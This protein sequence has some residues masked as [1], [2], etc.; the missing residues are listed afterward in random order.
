MV[1]TVFI[2]LS[3]LCSQVLA[4]RRAVALPLFFFS[5]ANL[6]AQ[7]SL[8]LHA[9]C[10]MTFS[11]TKKKYL[12]FLLALLLSTLALHAKGE[13]ADSMFSGPLAPLP[14][15]LTIL[16]EGNPADPLTGL[17]SVEGAFD[18]GKYDVTV[19]QWSIFLNAVHVTEGN[20]NDPRGLYPQEMLSQ[21]NGISPLEALSSLEKKEIV[22][23][24]GVEVIE[25]KNTFFFPH[26]YFLSVALKILS[27]DYFCA[28]L[29]IT[30][31]SR[32][33]AKRYC[34]WLHHGAPSFQ[35]LNEWTLLFTETGAYDFT[36]GKNGEL[37]PGARYFIP[38]LQQWYKAAYYHAL[39]QPTAGYF[40][41][42]TASNL[43]PKRLPSFENYFEDPSQPLQQHPNVKKTGA[44][45]A[46]L[47]AAWP[48]WKFYYKEEAGE[49][50]ILTTPVGSFKDSPGPY[51]TYDMGGNVR[52]WTSDF[53]MKKEVGSFDPKEISYDPTATKITYSYLAPGGSYEELSDQLLSTNASKKFIDALGDPTVGFR[54]AALANAH[55]NDQ[56]IENINY[57][58]GKSAA[59]TDALFNVALA[60]ITAY[61]LEA[62]LSVA[63]RNKRDIATIIA[64]FTWQRNITNTILSC[65]VASSATSVA[66]SVK[67]ATLW[68]ISYIVG[69]SLLTM[70][71]T[72]GFGFIAE[73]FVQRCLSG[74]TSLGLINITVLDSIESGSWER[75]FVNFY[76]IFFNTGSTVLTDLGYTNQSDLDYFNEAFNK[77]EEKTH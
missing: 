67:E 31:I 33:S 46:E 51:G 1:L 16:N 9:A 56:S 10:F 55:F 54:V 27:G 5:R 4:Y 77:A 68:N 43:L 65:I 2:T 40:L 22:H 13:F 47:A 15:M 62:F 60:Q 35:E 66:Q 58:D 76:Y 3:P 72:E 12:V 64:P 26:H 38:N 6:M 17:G 53:I 70:C 24:Y 28:Q 59:Y 37:Q 50:N 57:E 21:K 52:Q 41:Y 48:H 18:L 49:K 36:N 19:L 73:N 29:P 42:T 75:V 20:K 71:L 34:N 74:L 7:L 44:N 63:V 8:L 30:Q 32:D 45:Y 11:N 25:I 14:E 23:D 61:G 69:T 39:G